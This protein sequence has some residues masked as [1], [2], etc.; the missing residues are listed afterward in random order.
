LEP[1]PVQQLDWIG[2]GLCTGGWSLVA[3]VF[4]VTSHTTQFQKMKNDFPTTT[5]TTT[6][7][8]TTTT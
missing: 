3:S 8:I 4:D 2:L 1:H 6:T 5:T 7:T